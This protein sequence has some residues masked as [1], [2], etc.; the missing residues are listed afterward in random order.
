MTLTETMPEADRRVL[1]GFIGW[2]ALADE[3]VC[4]SVALGIRH[5]PDRVS[6]SSLL[7]QMR[8]EWAHHTY[9][10]RLVEDLG[11]TVPDRLPELE[12]LRDAVVDIADRSWLAFIVGFETTL[13]GIYGYPWS[14]AVMTAT[15]RD[16][17]YYK[18]YDTVLFPQEIGHYNFSQACLRK[19]LADDPDAASDV[20][21]IA[22]EAY[23]LQ[24]AFIESSFPYLEGIGA[25][26]SQ[27]LEKMEQIKHTYWPREYGLTLEEGYATPDSD[28]EYGP[29]M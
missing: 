13:D 26:Y 12:D 14:R 6:R 24:V 17:R 16:E 29:G 8:E 19:I 15:V 28:V 5:A 20:V 27:V 23:P 3:F 21:K 22:Q 4:N 2:H 1:C 10:A 18:F 25:D 9:F 11:G 7:R